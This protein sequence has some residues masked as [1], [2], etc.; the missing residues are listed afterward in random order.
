[1]VITLPQ[2]IRAEF[3]PLNYLLSFPAKQV[4][5]LLDILAHID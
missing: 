3:L 4:N 5:L 1:M 2:P